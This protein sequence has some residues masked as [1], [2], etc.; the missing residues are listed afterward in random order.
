MKD[1]K[2]DLLKRALTFRLAHAFMRICAYRHC[3]EMFQ[4]LA[5]SGAWPPLQLVFLQERPK[6]S[7]F[8]LSTD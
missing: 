4:H 2:R 3:Y 1:G 6:R 7:A 8:S 5:T